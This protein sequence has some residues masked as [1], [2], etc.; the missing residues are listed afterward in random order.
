MRRILLSIGTMNHL[1][2]GLMVITRILAK[3]LQLFQG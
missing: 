3:M 1:E 2:R